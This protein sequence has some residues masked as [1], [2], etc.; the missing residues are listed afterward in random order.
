MKTRMY[1]LG[2]LSVIVLIIGVMHQKNTS[3]LDYT[4]VETV[5]VETTH[6]SL[7]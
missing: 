1:V 4:V 6:A 7:K 2:C 5:E 3:F